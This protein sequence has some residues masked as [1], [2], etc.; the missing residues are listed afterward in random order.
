MK[1]I[2]YLLITSICLLFLYC[3]SVQKSNVFINDYMPLAIGNKW[4]YNFHTSEVVGIDTIEGK[5]Y[6]K[7]KKVNVN[8][9]FPPY[10]YHKRISNDTLYTLNYDQKSNLY[11]ERVTAIFTL[12]SGDVA[13]IELP[14][15]ELSSKNEAEGLP[16]GRS[17][18]IKVTNKDENTIE[19]FTYSGKIDGDYTEIY[20]RGV[21]MVKLKGGWG[22]IIELIDYD[23]NN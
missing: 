19:F 22:Q 21:G 17:Y 2:I 15:N 1:L 6:F 7:L 4:Y 9:K 12:D 8:T 11:F 16:T 18:S 20:K 5:K 23:L 3:S 14:P 13:R 10:S